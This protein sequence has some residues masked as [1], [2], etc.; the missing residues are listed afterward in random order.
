M[1]LNGL[2]NKMWQSVMVTQQSRFTQQ[3]KR[4]TQW[5]HTDCQFCLRARRI[6]FWLLLML[7]A[8]YF[9]FHLIFNR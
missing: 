3:L 6:I 2:I 7:V 5:W 8:D 4:L 1:V 9:W